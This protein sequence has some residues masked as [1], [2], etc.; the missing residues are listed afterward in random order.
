MFST[1]DFY[2]NERTLGSNPLG[3]PLNLM[4]QEEYKE[5]DRL[6]T[7]AMQWAEKQCQK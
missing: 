7:L 6:K 4:Q 1:E 5:I 3:K 2:T